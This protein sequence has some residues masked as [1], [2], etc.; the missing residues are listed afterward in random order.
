MEKLVHLTSA[1]NTYGGCLLILKREG[2]HLS[3]QDFGKDGLIY[4]A[5]YNG[6]TFAANS[7]VE[8]L[9]LFTLWKELGNNWNYP[10]LDI[11]DA[12]EEVIEE[13]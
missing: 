7:P 2:C 4:W 8:L 5:E 11:W 6:N 10:S 3:S 12:V 13:S 1:G 9:G